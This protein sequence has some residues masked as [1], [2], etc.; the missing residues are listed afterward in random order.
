MLKCN[1]VMG[2]YIIRKDGKIVFQSKNKHEMFRTLSK[3]NGTYNLIY[4]R[5]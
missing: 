1:Y 2:W 4:G 5:G 3:M